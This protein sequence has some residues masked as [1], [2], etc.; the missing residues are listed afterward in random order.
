MDLTTEQRREL[1]RRV[2]SARIAKYGTRK[3]A[4]IAAG[5]N[6]ETWRKAEAGEP[7]AERSLIAIVKLL[8]PETEGDWHSITPPLTEASI[9][10]Q[11]ANSS[12]SESAKERLLRLLDEERE[13]HPNSNRGAS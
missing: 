9:E 13:R 1:A 8:W 6:S 12:L 7:L 11:I 4:Y 2:T 3:A 5:L 10:D